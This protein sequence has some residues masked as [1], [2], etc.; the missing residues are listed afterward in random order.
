MEQL[1]FIAIVPPEDIR[2]KIVAIKREFADRYG[3]SHAL[4]SPAHITLHMPFKWKETKR[5]KLLMTLESTAQSMSSFEIQLSGFGAFIPRVIYVEVMENDQ[6][7]V[8]QKRISSAMR[9]LN[10]LNADYK[11][12]PYHPHMTVAFRDLKKPAFHQAWSEFST[13][14]FSGKFLA[15]S[16]VLLRHVQESNERPFWKIERSY[17]MQSTPR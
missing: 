3:S 12:R 2:D 8:C 5:E 7:Q 1:Y 14:Q 13:R 10:V 9:P 4:R 6:L 11:D 15:E 17:P 16:I